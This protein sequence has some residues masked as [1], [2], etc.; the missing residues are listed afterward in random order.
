VNGTDS[1]FRQWLGGGFYDQTWFVML[2]NLTVTADFELQPANLVFVS[3]HSYPA[4]AGSAAAFDDDCNALATAAGINTLTGDAY[5]AWVSDGASTA[6]S[7]IGAARGWVRIDGEPFGDDLTDMLSNGAIFNAPLLDEHGQP[8]EYG[9]ASTVWT[10]TNPDGSADPTGD[11]GDW[12]VTDTSTKAAL[13]N[14]F[15][16]P[17]LWTTATKTTGCGTVQ[18]LLC[19]GTAHGTPVSPH[20]IAGKRTFLSNTPWNPGAPGGD[21][22]ADLHCDAEKP[23]GMGAVRALIG[24]STRAPSSV[25]VEGTSY[26][27]LD[28]TLVGTGA[29]I[30]RDYYTRPL[31][32]GIWQAGDGTYPIAA[33]DGY[34]WT[35]TQE[36]NSPSTG[37]VFDCS[38]WTSSSGGSGTVGTFG[39]VDQS[40]P[41]WWFG[42]VFS[43]CDNPLHARVYCVE[44]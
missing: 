42:A 11:C 22:D 38:D 1:Y 44:Q 40:S 23:P 30:E 6:A 10:G 18:Q 15:G 27:R 39:I 33:T 13:G 28:G 12:T 25:M 41:D 14:V 7:R 37:I 31:D 34:V 43:T 32:S 2:G 16:G 20:V 26:V 8:P 17:K 29:E 9:Y 3:S 24:T 21:G 5:V 4:N 35:G 19:F 36:V